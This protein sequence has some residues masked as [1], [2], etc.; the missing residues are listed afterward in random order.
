[1]NAEF[2][3]DPSLPPRPQIDM[4]ELKAAMDAEMSFLGYAFLCYVYND[5]LIR[6]HNEKVRQAEGDAP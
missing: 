1:M 4:D 2:I 5:E 6:R 3:G